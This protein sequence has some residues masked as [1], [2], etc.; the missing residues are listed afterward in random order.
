M[1]FRIQL[2]IV[3]PLR[4]DVRNVR[5]P[6]ADSGSSVERNEAAAPVSHAYL[7][8]PSTL[9]EIF[10][11]KVTVSTQPKSLVSSTTIPLKL[12]LMPLLSFAVLP[13][14]QDNGAFHTT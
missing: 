1:H 5:F 10:W 8:D 4:A 6:K 9:P 14:S 12:T 13:A 2:R 7:C 3:D 11:H